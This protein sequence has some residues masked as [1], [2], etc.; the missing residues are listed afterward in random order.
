MI[1]VFFHCSK[2]ANNSESD[3]VLFE[4]EVAVM[5]DVILQG[6]GFIAGL[7]LHDSIYTIGYNYSYHSGF[8]VF[9]FC[10]VSRPDKVLFPPPNWSVSQSLRDEQ[11]IGPE[12]QQVFEV[13][14]A[15]LQTFWQDFRFN[16]SIQF[17]LVPNIFLLYNQTKSWLDSAVQKKIICI[18]SSTPLSSPPNTKANINRLNCK[19]MDLPL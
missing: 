10:S 1:F 4:L 17:L 16:T 2:N 15:S 8:S 18:N 14:W 6:W 13:C 7:P 9:F 12:L 3:V 11:D 5:A 19:K